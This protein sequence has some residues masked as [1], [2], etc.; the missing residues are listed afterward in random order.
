MPNEQPT[1]LEET[2][3][4]VDHLCGT[5]GL[6][7]AVIGG[8][9]ATIYGSARTTIDV[10]I[11]VQTELETLERVYSVF[12]QSFTPLT[13]DPLQFFK[14]YFVLP[15]VHSTL[16]TKLDVSA[17]LSEFERTALQRARRMQYG[18]ATGTFCTP[19]D[20]ILFKLV[21]C[22][23]RDLLDAKDIITRNR[24]RLDRSYLHAVAQ[25]FVQV[26]RPDVVQNL[27][28]LLDAS[29]TKEQSQS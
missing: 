9:A 13:E 18:S 7:Y 26:E 29:D 24:D 21:A 17:A 3:D 10:D 25:E 1:P 23:E 19:E 8:I 4:L 2:I 16:R 5:N 22:R 12:T 27:K 6:A 11:I 15:L 14:T 20:L 28:R